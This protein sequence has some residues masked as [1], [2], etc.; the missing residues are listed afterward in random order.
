MPH[1]CLRGAL[2]HAII[3]NA[4]FV[5]LGRYA[6]MVESGVSLCDIVRSVISDEKQDLLVDSFDKYNHFIV[7]M[8]NQ[9]DRRR[10]QQTGIKTSQS[11]NLNVD[12]NT[13]EVLD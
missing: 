10:T 3:Q 12:L 8:S 13:G 6:D 5:Q 11:V 4:N 1:V 2:Y 7:A 9:F